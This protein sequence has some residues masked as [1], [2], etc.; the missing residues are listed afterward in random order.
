[1]T[2]SGPRTGCYP[3]SFNPLT[4]AHLALAEA[5]VATCRLERIDLVVSKVALAKEHV[6]RPSLDDRLSVLAEAVDARR[7]WLGLV[8][9]DRQLLVELAEGYDVLVMG[10]DKWLQIRDPAFYGGSV[11]ARD[12]ALARLPEV[13]IAERPGWTADAVVGATS[14]R[15]P[16]EVAGASS[17][18][19]R[20]GETEWMAPEAAAFDRRSGAWTD[21]ARYDQWQRQR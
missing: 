18:R 17:T 12:R 15:L 11:T 10:T 6:D 5:A 13:A 4:R 7:S 20:Q 19:V 2:P 9:S 14:L 3:G 8:V 16:S 21:P 1:V